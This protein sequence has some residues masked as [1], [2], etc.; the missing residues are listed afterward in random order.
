MAASSEIKRKRVLVLGEIKAGKSKF[1]AQAMLHSGCSGAAVAGPAEWQRSKGLRACHVNYFNRGNLCLFDTEGWIGPPPLDQVRLLC[2]GVTT[3]TA[4]LWSSDL[5]SAQDNKADLVVV[6][7]NGVS[8]ARRKRGWFG[9]YG[10]LANDVVS[11]IEE[12]FEVIKNV[13]Q[14]APVLLITHQDYFERSRSLIWNAKY[15]AELWRTIYDRLSR[16]WQSNVFAVG[17]TCT[18]STCSNPDKC[19]CEYAGEAVDQIASL[20]YTAFEIV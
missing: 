15:S 1:V 8:L 13:T 20:L 3:G 11:G 16:Q 9:E 18:P 7:V 12:L 6:V 10:E 5:V 19:D 17:T 4:P 14:R 2:G